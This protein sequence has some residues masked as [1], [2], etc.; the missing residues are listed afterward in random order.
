MGEP[1]LTSSGWRL[2]VD[3]S[4]CRPVGSVSQPRDSGD[5]G[6]TVKR[7]RMDWHCSSSA[8]RRLAVLCVAA[9]CAAAAQV[10]VIDGQ[11]HQTAIDVSRP[12]CRPSDQVNQGIQAEPLGDC[13]HL[14]TGTPSGIFS[15][16]PCK[17]RDTAFNAFCQ[18]DKDG[19]HWTVI[20]RRGDVEPR[21]DFNLNWS[22]YTN[23]FGDLNGEFWLGLEKIY[24][25]VSC[26]GQ[27]K[28]RIDM[29]A[30][31]LAKGYAQYGAF[32]IG[33]EA[34]GYKLS[35]SNFTGNVIDRLSFDNNNKFSTRDRDQDGWRGVSCAERRNSGW[36]YDRCS[37]T[38]LNG[39]YGGCTDHVSSTWTSWSGF[40]TPLMKIA[41][42]MRPT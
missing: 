36:W 16:K 15:L 39:V 26:G 12:D 38:N 35:V 17:N 24:Q 5:A 20:Q 6:A 30:F 1:P 34:E 7:Y 37:Y 41:M 23:G 21:Q 11:T 14:P 9:G 28:L 31:S 32:S 29:K 2:A 19:S 3:V 4:G 18:M 27:Y 13:S 22:N 42:K 40:A 25:M 10:G 33:S 8:V